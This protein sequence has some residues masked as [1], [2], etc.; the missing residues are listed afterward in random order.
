M[1]KETLE[2]IRKSIKDAETRLTELKE[3]IDKAR[4]AEIDVKDMEAVYRDLLT[5]TTALKRVYG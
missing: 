1:K 2:A 3:D 4:R 5:K